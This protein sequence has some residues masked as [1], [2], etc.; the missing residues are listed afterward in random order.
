MSLTS[1]RLIQ[2]AQL[3][4]E[5]AVH[6]LLDA[7]SIEKLPSYLKMALKQ[8]PE[9]AHGKLK[10]VGEWRAGW[11]N[12]GPYYQATAEINVRTL[13]AAVDAYMHICGTGTSVLGTLANSDVK[14]FLRLAQRAI[15]AGEV[16]ASRE[17]RAHLAR[18][19]TR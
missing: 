15:D 16:A 5:A 19:L 17:L 6:R 9:L 8:P 11:K 7:F 3:D 12:G 10:I 18:A 14:I 4:E 13:A 2:A 1:I